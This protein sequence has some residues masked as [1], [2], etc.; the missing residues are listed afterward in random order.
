MTITQIGTRSRRHH[1]GVGALDHVA[2]QIA[3]HKRHAS[4]SHGRVDTV[5]DPT[6]IVVA[7]G[8]AGL[9]H[10]EYLRQNPRL[11]GMTLSIRQHPVKV[12][13]QTWSHTVVREFLVLDQTCQE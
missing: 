8:L 10:G 6:G 3:L 13:H 9:L 12:G 2:E 5:Y 7:P 4:V 11:T 1:R